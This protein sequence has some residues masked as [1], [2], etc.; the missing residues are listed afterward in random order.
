MIERR[1]ILVGTLAAFTQ[2]GAVEAQPTGKVT[3]IGVLSFGAPEPFRE[4]FRQALLELGY[5]EG[6]N[7]VVEHRW[8]DGQTDRLSTL[9]AALLRANVDVIVA[10][11][12]PSVQAAMAATRHV[13]IVMAAAGDA[14]R[15]GLVTNLAR[16][17]GNVTGLSLSLVEL[18]GKTVE[19]LRETLPRSTVVAAGRS[20]HRMKEAVAWL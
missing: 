7:V 5:A 8:A 13:P 12:T 17:G 16:P 10:S 1:A 3:R 14:L 19:L 18:A 15:T 2:A 11:A 4:G 6:R 9:A 20:C